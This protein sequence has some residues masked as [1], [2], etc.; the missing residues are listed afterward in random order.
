MG[1]DPVQTSGWR[2]S[3]TKHI[4]FFGA[5]FVLALIAEVLLVFALPFPKV[6]QHSLQLGIIVEIHL[7][8]EKNG[9]QV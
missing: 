2:G 4:V 7:C 5:F 6:H 9:N 3:G 1:F 8:L